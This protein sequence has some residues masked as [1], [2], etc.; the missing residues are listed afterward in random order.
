MCV[1]LVYGSRMAVVDVVAM[2]AVL[3]LVQ[4][5]VLLQLLAWRGFLSVQ[6]HPVVL[7]GWSC[8]HTWFPLKVEELLL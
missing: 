8:C 6:I 1:I 4:V 2:L 5:H 7:L 3:V